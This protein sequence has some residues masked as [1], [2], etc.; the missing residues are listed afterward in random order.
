MLA[1]RNNIARD[2]HDEIGSTLTSIKILSE[3][4]KNNLEK[5]V[6]KASVMLS[7]ITEQ[8]TQ[9][10]QG[11]SDIIWAIKPDN[12]KMENMLV[13]MR[14]YAAYALESKDIDVSFVV[15]ND[16]LEKNLD[17]QQRRDVFL[18]FKEAVNNAAKYSAA[19][20]MKIKL[21]KALNNIEMEITDNGKGFERVENPLMNGLK[22]MQVRATSLNAKL[23]IITGKNKGTSVIVKI[24]AT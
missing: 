6:G 5:D 3:V 10:Q 23:E 2:L 24:P 8:S 13:R 9:M 18:I 16:V 1:V 7:K 21:Q 11:M 19:V 15:D 17:M 14:E 22:N 4:S 20:S 12:D